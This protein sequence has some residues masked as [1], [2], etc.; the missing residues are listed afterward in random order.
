[1]KFWLMMLYYHY[2]SKTCVRKF[3]KSTSKNFVLK[4][5]FFLVLE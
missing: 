1:M 3:L 4:K 2:F 5:S